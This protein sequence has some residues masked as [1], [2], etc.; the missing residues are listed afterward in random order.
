MID[1]QIIN[2]SGFV[3]NKEDVRTLRERHR[4]LGSCIGFTPKTFN[5]NLPFILMPVEIQLLK[6]KNIIKLYKLASSSP[7]S[8]GKISRCVFEALC[9][10]F[11][12][13]YYRV[14][15]KKG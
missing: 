7:P 2:N 1:V 10:I 13:V 5:M 4:I 8:P 6:E 15:Q 3:W 14:S 11:I 12:L 9:Y